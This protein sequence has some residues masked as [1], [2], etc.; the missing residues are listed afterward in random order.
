MK[1]TGP[2]AP[3]QR[4]VLLF[5]LGV[6]FSVLTTWL[7]RSSSATASTLPLWP[8]SS[9]TLRPPLACHT[10]TVRSAPHEA[11]SEKAAHQTKPWT[12]FEWCAHV[13]VRRSRAMSQ[14]CDY[15]CCFGRGGAQQEGKSPRGARREVL[16]R[17]HAA[18]GGGG[19]GGGGGGEI[20]RP[21]RSKP[22]AAAPTLTTATPPPP[23]THTRAP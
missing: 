11:K 9:P 10:G 1:G 8:R 6:N 17:V 14:T 21:S 18:S 15:C 23:H 4:P 22:T 19:G 7:V 5:L 3:L 16:L 12:P 2:G 20:E 13:C